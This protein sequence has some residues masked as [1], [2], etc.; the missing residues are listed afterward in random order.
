MSWTGALGLVIVAFALSSLIALIAIGLAVASEWASSGFAPIGWSAV[1]AAADATLRSP[2]ILSLAQLGGLTVAAAIG[3]LVAFGDA[4]EE[5]LKWRDALA[6]RA[7]PIP[8]AVLAII[9]GFAMQL[10]LH[11]LTNLLLDAVPALRFDVPSRDLVRSVVRID[12]VRDAVVVPFAF[13]V[14]PAL[15]E[16]LLFRGLLLPGLSRRY[17]PAIGLIGSSALFALMHVLPAAL[18][19]TFIAGLALG[20]VRRRTGSV[21]PCIAMHGAFNALAII[22]PASVVRIEGFNTFDA[23]G[24]AHI[25]LPLVLGSAVCTLAALFAI[26]HLSMRDSS[27]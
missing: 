19:F 2:V 15:S 18:P 12:S 13:V 26:E 20:H 3:T 17:T 11:E 14:V 9:A 5:E 1:E 8:I 21:M 10:P 4:S 27:R 7:V 22:V 16:E 24:V 23:D 25:P 6:L